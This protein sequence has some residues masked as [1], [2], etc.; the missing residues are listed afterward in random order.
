[1]L[2][3][4]DNELIKNYLR[5]DKK[6]FDL[7]IQKYTK[8][9]YGFIYRQIGNSSESEDITQEVFIRVWRNIKKFKIEK[10]FKTW[11]FTIAKNASVDFLRKKK[12]FVFSQ[13]ENEEGENMLTET[14]ADPAP[15]PQEIFDKKNL[16][17]TV[18]TAIRAL[19]PKY[20]SL[21]FLH[22]NEYFSFQEISEILHEPINTVKSRHRRAI[23]E[24]K[25]HL[26]E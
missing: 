19:S 5:G 14:L 15:L 13:F 2:T 3:D 16:S 22:Y 9:I 17:E 12:S 8:P 20:Q 7:L 11:I 10:N 1:M 23:I 4:N 6:S 25:K 24:L 21:L 26:I 18:E